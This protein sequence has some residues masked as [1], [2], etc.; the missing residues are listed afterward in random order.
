MNLIIKNDM[1]LNVLQ[2]A[3]DDIIYQLEDNLLA[4]EPAER[5]IIEERLNAAKA[6]K[7]R[8]EVEFPAGAI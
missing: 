1:E 5:Y 7:T 6:L 4:E 2:V 8:L 3:V